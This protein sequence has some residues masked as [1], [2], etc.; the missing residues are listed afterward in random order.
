MIGLV[1]DADEPDRLRD[2][3]D[4][5]PETVQQVSGSRTSEHHFL[6]VPGLDEDLPLV[7]PDTGDELG[8]IK[9]A[10]QSYVVGPGSI[11]PSGNRYG[12]LQG[13]TIA[14]VPEDELREVL[15]PF[16]PDESNAP[17]PRIDRSGG[18]DRRRP[19][20]ERL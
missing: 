2:L 3:L 17:E 14:T 10:E 16:R 18:F 1:V 11:H 5:L 13:D 15:E 6:L 7:D 12:P 8:H 9:A 19:R 4:A 20:V